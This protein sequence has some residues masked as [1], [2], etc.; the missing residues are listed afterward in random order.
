MLG[1]WT[2]PCAPLQTR[3][4]QG[5][6]NPQPS[7]DWRPGGRAWSADLRLSASLSLDAA[8]RRGWIGTCSRG[9]GRRGQP[10]A[11]PG[12]HLCHFGRPEDRP[13][14]R[15]PWS[16]APGAPPRGAVCRLHLAAS[17]LFPSLSGPER[18]TK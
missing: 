3:G 5:G 9:W 16:P 11:P 6:G 7:G 2:G 12:L 10:W 8:T 13:P 17:S 15:A 4:G 18:G 1:S 14:L